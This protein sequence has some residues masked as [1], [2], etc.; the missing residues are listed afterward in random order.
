MTN[1]NQ[2]Y[3]NE[4]IVTFNGNDNKNF[5]STVCDNQIFVAVGQKTSNNLNNISQV[6]SFNFWDV[7]PD[8]ILNLQDTN[9]NIYDNYRTLTTGTLTGLSNRQYTNLE[10]D[11]T[12]PVQFTTADNNVTFD[13]FNTRDGM[14][15]PISA[16]KDR[17][18]VGSFDLKTTTPSDVNCNY[19][20]GNY[21]YI[22]GE[23][24][25][26]TFNG[27]IKKG[28]KITIK[29]NTRNDVISNILFDSIILTTI[30]G[31]SK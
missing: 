11:L 19:T 4:V 9:I 22:K 23:P 24:V 30:G 7:K 14:T 31:I 27:N 29:R 5:D 25:N 12:T 21:S 3:K 10:L 13:D 28:D 15:Q 26:V 2:K 18:N 1:Y 6:K 20:T 17:E 8:T 16:L